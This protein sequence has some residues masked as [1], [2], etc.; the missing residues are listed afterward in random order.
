LNRSYPAPPI[1]SSNEPTT[2][3]PSAARRN[4]GT[5]LPAACATRREGDSGDAC[6]RYQRERE[7]EEGVASRLNLR[8][9]ERHQECLGPRGPNQPTPGPS[10]SAD[11][12]AVQS[13]H[14]SCRCGSVRRAG[15]VHSPS[16]DTRSIARRADRGLPSGPVPA[17]DPPRRVGRSR[18]RAFACVP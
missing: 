17:V 18:A 3:S 2:S 1:D 6:E 10:P 8:H 12:S 14:P 9:D 13:S 4:Q 7:V 15:R 16:K 5:P 11:R